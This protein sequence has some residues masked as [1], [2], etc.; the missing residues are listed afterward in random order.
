MNR[1]RNA[2]RHRRQLFLSLASLVSLSFFPPSRKAGRS[3]SLGPPRQ[4]G[5]PAGPLACHWPAKREKD[6]MGEKG[7]R[8]GGRYARPGQGGRSN[9]QVRIKESL[10]PA[11]SVSLGALN[12]SMS[13]RVMEKIIT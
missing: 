10:S 12:D 7:K 8:G 1:S 2:H 9:G 3:I 4:S 13:M 11:L 6:E 5:F